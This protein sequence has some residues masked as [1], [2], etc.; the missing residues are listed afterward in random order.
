MSEQVYSLCRIELV[1]T[2]FSFDASTTLP[3]LYSLESSICVSDTANQR[4]DSEL[5]KGQKGGEKGGWRKLLET[6]Q[7][8]NQS[9]VPTKRETS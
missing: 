4:V 6:K 8:W 9:E 2:E 7:D 3:F 5:A 1:L